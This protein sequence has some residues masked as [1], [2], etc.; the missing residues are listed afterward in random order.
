MLTPPV[1]PVLQCSGAGVED[2]G[3]RKKDGALHSRCLRCIFVCRLGWL[4]SSGATNMR[5]G[6]GVDVP[7]FSSESCRRQINAC[8]AVVYNLVG[9]GPTERRICGGG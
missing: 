5:R 2:G 3:G 1:D 9:S 7:T 4:G 6:R 8:I